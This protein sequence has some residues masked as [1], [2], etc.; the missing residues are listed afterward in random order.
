[1]FLVVSR[2]D[3]QRVILARGHSDRIGETSALSSFRIG[4]SGLG[5]SPGLA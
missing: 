2:D 1:M 5:V 4:V 3:S